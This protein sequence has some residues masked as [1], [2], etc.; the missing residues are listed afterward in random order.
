MKPC[1]Y[2]L[3]ILISLFL[4]SLPGCSGEKERLSSSVSQGEKVSPKNVSRKNA[5]SSQLRADSITAGT[6]E[7]E[8]DGEVYQAWNPDLTNKPG[9][10][11]TGFM[12]TSTV[13]NSTPLPRDMNAFAKSQKDRANTADALIVIFTPN[14]EFY[15]T[16]ENQMKMK[17]AIADGVFRQ[18]EEDFCAD[19]RRGKSQESN[20]IQ[21]YMNNDGLRGVFGLY[22]RSYLDGK[23]GL[24]EKLVLDD[25]G[26]Y[27][28]M[29]IMGQDALFAGTD[30]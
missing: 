7:Y 6:R 8:K 22:R 15:V 25:N 27:I 4:F 11:V 23:P 14:A 2:S 21:C 17:K 18:A 29:L 9:S 16:I 1:Y 12:R 30:K 28:W 3:L 10:E 26:S 19:E 5:G 13:A 24:F 20:F